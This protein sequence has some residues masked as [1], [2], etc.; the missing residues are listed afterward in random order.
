[1]FQDETA[2]RECLDASDAFD[3][4]KEARGIKNNSLGVTDEV[5]EKEVQVAAIKESMQALTTCLA[6]LMKYRSATVLQ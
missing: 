6:E 4:F 3:N 2:R 5:F 1:M